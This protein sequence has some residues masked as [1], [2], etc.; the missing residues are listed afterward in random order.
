M[1]PATVCMLMSSMA[2]PAR[3]RPVRPMGVRVAATMTASLASV[4]GTSSSG[5]HED[6]NRELVGDGLERD[7]QGHSHL[8]LLEGAVDDVGHHARPLDQ[9]DNGGHVGHPIAKG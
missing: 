7:L 2:S 9:V 8:Q 4:M 6:G 1:T 5:P 3:A